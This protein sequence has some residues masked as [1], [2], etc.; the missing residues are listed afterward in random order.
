MSTTAHAHPNI[1]LVKYWGKSGQ[2][3]NIPATPSLSI[4]LAGLSTTTTVSE[5]AADEFLLNG[6]PADDPKVEQCLT[7]LREQ[8]DVPPVR[9]SSRNDFPTA[10]GLA[11]SASGFAALITAL[12]AEFALGLDGSGR[13]VLARQASA[14]AARS[15]FG[16]FA[17]LEGPEWEAQPLFEPLHWP[18]QVVVAVTDTASKSVSSTTGMQRSALSPYFPGWVRSTREDFTAACAAVAER[19]FDTLVELAEH[20]CLK[21]HGLML[22]TRPPLSYWNP[23]TLACMETIR[24]LRADGTEVFFTVDAGPQVKAIC[25]PGH[26]QT[27]HRALAEVPGVTRLIDAELGQGAWV[28]P[29]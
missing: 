1:A 26:R 29:P 13:S 12:N 4:T 19:D 5:A 18:L 23:T 3:G 16:G 8:F 15:I 17:T 27:V 6:E 21:M 2:P 24:R 22:S 7:R 28:D 20:S 25:L 11:S 14:S 10:A 9:V